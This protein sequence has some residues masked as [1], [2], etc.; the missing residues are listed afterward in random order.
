VRDPKQ[1]SPAICRELLGIARVKAQDD[2]AGV[3]RLTIDIASGHNRD[4]VCEELVRRWVAAGIGVLGVEPKAVRLE[5]IFAA[6]TNEASAAA[7]KSKEG[8]R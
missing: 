5:D 2:G 6:L 3:L 4:T 7:M 1:M 8:S